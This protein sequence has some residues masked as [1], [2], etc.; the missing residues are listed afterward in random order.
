MSTLQYPKI[1]NKLNDKGKCVP[2]SLKKEGGACPP[3]ALAK[4]GEKNV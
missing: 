2:R 3:E 1:Q 4:G